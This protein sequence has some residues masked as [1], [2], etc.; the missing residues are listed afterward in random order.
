MK[1]IPYASA[2]GSIKYATL[3]TRTIVYLVMSLA[4]GYNSDPGVD[5]WAM[6][7]IILRRLRKYFSIMEV[8]KGSSYKVTSMQ[9]LTPIWM[10]LSLDLD[11]Y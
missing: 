11:T 2:I 8:T 10:T 6:V 5:H 3:Y 4:K 9:V 1:V 7:K